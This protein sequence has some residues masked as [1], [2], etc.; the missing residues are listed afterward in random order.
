V[1]GRGTPQQRFLRAC[2]AGG[3]AEEARRRVRLSRATF[4]ERLGFY[5]DLGW[6][7][8]EGGSVSATAEGIAGALSFLARDHLS[9][10]PDEPI[11]L[12]DRPSL[13]RTGEIGQVERNTGRL[14]ARWRVVVVRR[15]AAREVATLTEFG[16]EVRAVIPTRESWRAE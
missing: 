13:K 10:W 9:R 11:P 2:A 5:V 12:A 15:R 6:L 3:T 16:R 1:A 7:R 8:H 14:L 4:Y